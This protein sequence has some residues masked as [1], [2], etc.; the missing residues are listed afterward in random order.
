MI[1]LPWK[2]LGVALLVAAAM[3]AWQ[4]QYNRGY[5]AGRAFEQNQNQIALNRAAIVLKEAEEDWFWRSFNIGMRL[6]TQQTKIEVVTN[7]IREEIPIYITPEVDTQYPLPNSFV[8]LH[9]A[10]A[11]GRS[12]AEL[13]SRPGEPAGVATEFTLSDTTQLLN[14]NYA[15]CKYNAAQL[16]ALQQWARDMEDWWAELRESW[17]NGG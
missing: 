14:A 10:A 5:A 13:P 7:V 15:V 3:F 2:L 9:D 17:P 8:W 6:A 1:P 16:E 11:S 4:R 12:V